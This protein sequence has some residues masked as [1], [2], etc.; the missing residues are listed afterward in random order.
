MITQTKQ[1]TDFETSEEVLD[2]AKDFL[3]QYFIQLK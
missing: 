1:A 2:D 3:E